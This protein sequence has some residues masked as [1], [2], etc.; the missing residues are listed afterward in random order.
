[1]KNNSSLIFMESKWIW[2]TTLS[3]MGKDIF[4]YLNMMFEGNRVFE[5]VSNLSGTDGECKKVA[6]VQNQQLHGN[7]EILFSVQDLFYV[8]I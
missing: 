7:L 4:L 8:R 2:N 6:F 1:M 3:G 5:I